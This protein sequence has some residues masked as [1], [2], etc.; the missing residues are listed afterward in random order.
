LG[1]GGG[2]AT[3]RRLAWGWLNQPQAKQGGWPHPMGWFGHPS[4][5]LLLSFFFFLIKYVMGAFWEKMVELQQFE[6]LGELSV[7]FET[8]EV[9]VQMGG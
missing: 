3:P 8:L 5:F 6:S 1:L 4:I 2:S 9:K 7:T